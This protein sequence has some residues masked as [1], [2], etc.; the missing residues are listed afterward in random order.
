MNQHALRHNFTEWVWRKSQATG[1][2]PSGGRAGRGRAT[3]DTAND[4]NALSPWL[5][6]WTSWLDPLR[7]RGYLKGADMASVFEGVRSRTEGL[8]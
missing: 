1:K 7:S 6:S 3:R 2:R 5:P 8:Q 4:Y